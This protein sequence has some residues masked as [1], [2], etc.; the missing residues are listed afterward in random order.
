VIVATCAAF[1]VLPLIAL[2]GATLA[3]CYATQTTLALF[4]WVV[5]RRLLPSPDPKLAFVTLAVLELTVFALFLARGRDV[6][7]SAN[8]AALIAAIVYALVIP[9]TSWKVDGDE[10]YYLMITESVLHDGDLDLA[11]QYRA[12]DTASGRSD[13]RGPQHIDDPRGP[14]GELYSRHEPFLS[15]LMAPGY[16]LGGLHGAL[17][18]IAFF[19]VLLVRS[20]V[21]WMEDEG[22]PDEAARA[23]FPLFAFA[24]PILWYA[25]RMW[26]EVPAAFFFVEALRGVRSHRA[27]RW[28]PALLGLVL[29][30]VRF[31]LVA[32]GLLVAGM[33]AR[34]SRPFA[35]AGALAVVAVPLIVMWA[36]SIHSWRE[37]IPAPPES[38]P[39]GLF[40]LLVDGMS[41]LAFQAPFY[42]FGLAALIRWRETPRGFR[43]GI[44]ASLLYIFYLLPRQESFSSY[45]PP[46]RYMVFLMPVL[47]LGAAWLWERI[48]RGAI[49]IVSAWT[50]GLVIHGIVYPFRLFHEATGENAV[51]EWL[52]RL[53]QSDFSRLFPSFIRLNHAAWIGAAVVVTLI[54][55]LHRRTESTALQIAF[56]ALVLAFGFRLGREPGARVEFEDTHVLH[57]G[58]HVEPPMETINRSVHRGGW[59][60]H[61]GE[62]LTFLARAGTHHLYAITGRGATIELGGHAYRVEPSLTHRTIRVTIP[63]DGRVTLRCLS[64]AVNLDRM[65]LQ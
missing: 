48:P 35:I 5:W 9:A 30:K 56:V 43:T 4:A 32:L 34:R 64:G 27:K 40:G 23:V 25:T 61:D 50:I 42:L 12:G 7:W 58:G 29:L 26:A 24:P 36:F 47:A 18:V 51:G 37:L 44:L 59:L 53:Y 57:D 11:N 52:S 28:V 10:P 2:R 46:L 20:T 33:R 45:G 65:D 13:L 49:A 17:A 62:S 3:R 14:N 21:R 63:N 41:G 6:R 38:Y 31:G 8:R 1:L 16:A 39:R 60:L 55:L 22:V 19:G 15:L 54:V